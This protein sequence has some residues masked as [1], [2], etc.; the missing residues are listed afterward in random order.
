M[1]ELSFYFYGD[2]SNN[3]IYWFLKPDYCI[4][5]IKWSFIHLPLLLLFFFLNLDFLKWCS[6]V[7]FW[8]IW[9]DNL[10]LLWSVLFIYDRYVIG[11]IVWKGVAVVA[12]VETVTAEATT[13]IAIATGRRRL[14]DT[15][16]NSNANARSC[17]L[18]FSLRNRKFQFADETHRWWIV[19]GK[20]TTWLTGLA[21]RLHIDSWVL[22]FHFTSS[23]YFFFWFLPGFSGYF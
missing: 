21:S 12:A 16:G 23:R 6:K 20:T 22:Q 4:S 8:V 1:S 14:R 18:E 17:C 19:T 5:H 9:I 2:I 11:R 15:T 13:A 3:V 10:N 7:L